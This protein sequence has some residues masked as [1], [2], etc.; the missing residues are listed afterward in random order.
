M[1]NVPENGASQE[2]P[3]YMADGGNIQGPCEL[4]MF[5]ALNSMA[6]IDSGKLRRIA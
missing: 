5:F 1:Q 3:E 6:G 2:L 4:T